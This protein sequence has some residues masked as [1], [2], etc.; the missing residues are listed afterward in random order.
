MPTKTLLQE[1]Q[2][3]LIVGAGCSGLSLARELA[4]R[5]YRGKVVLLDQRT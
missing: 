4:L 3:L 5:G 1:T 2:D